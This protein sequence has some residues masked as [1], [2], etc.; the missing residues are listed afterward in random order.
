MLKNRAQIHNCSVNNI[1]N[2]GRHV[3]SLTSSENGEECHKELQHNNSKDDKVDS[4]SVV[5]LVD[6]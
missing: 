4:S 3:M 6:T 1:N 2:E 5:P